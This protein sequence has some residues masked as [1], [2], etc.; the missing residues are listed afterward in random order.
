MKTTSLASVMAIVMLC[1]CTE[2][3]VYAGSQNP[4]SAALNRELSLNDEQAV[5]ATI[6]AY[7]TA[8]LAN[9]AKQVLRTFTEDAALM[10]AQGG[11]PVVG[12]AAIEKYWFA[13][14]GPPTT[15]T[16]LDITVDQVRG[17]SGFAFVR[18]LNGV[19]WTVTEHGTAHKHFHPG[20]YLDVMR[21]LADGS[22][23]IQ[24]HMWDV[25]PERLE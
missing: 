21:K 5:R 23:R 24:V 14:G 12:I 15:V 25:G 11:P 9:D 13:A 2:V 16:R 17:N 7:R 18:G 6:E 1:S 10:P 4:S 19:G 20:T 3:P 8:W 22:W